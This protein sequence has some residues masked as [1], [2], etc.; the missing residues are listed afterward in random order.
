MTYYN[1]IADTIIPERLSRIT[2][3]Q[4]C[5]KLLNEQSNGYEHSLVVPDGI[6]FFG[7]GKTGNYHYSGVDTLQEHLNF[8][9]AHTGNEC[10]RIM[11]K[12]KD[13][14]NQDIFNIQGEI[15][16]DRERINVK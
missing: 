6:L 12:Y 14:I 1:N 4:D 15:E 11:L 7:V 3:I 13:Y 16:N 5:K 10:Y 8:V 2:K 9:E